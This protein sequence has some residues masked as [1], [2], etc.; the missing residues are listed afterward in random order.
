LKEL[1]PA[2]ASDRS[3]FFTT[4]SRRRACGVRTLYEHLDYVYRQAASYCVIFMS[5][6]YARKAWTQHEGKS[7]FARAL[8]ADTQY[9]L[10]IRFDDMELP[11]LRPTIAYVD[12]RITTRDELVEMI[13]QKI[14]PSGERTSMPAFPAL[15]LHA[16]GCVLGYHDE[17]V[18]SIALRHDDRG[19]IA[20]S[21][22]YDNCVRIWH[23]EQRA[24]LGEFARAETAIRNITLTRLGPTDVLVAGGNNGTIRGWDVSTS[25][26]V[27]EPFRAH[28]G[29]VYS[30]AAATVG[31]R[32][33]VVSSGAD[34]KTY[35]WDLESSEMVSVI[36]DNQ[37]RSSGKPKL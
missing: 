32:T 3:A 1:L 18:S 30:V 33:L 34:R 29:A 11:G 6:D 10:P 9:I 4:P 16:D 25:A 19:L 36:S 13:V 17:T 21:G 27:I 7:A 5:A 28:R 2:C 37:P 12:L 31:G 35:S 24:G 15:N 8:A 22:G 23:L 20:Y 26:T 14:R